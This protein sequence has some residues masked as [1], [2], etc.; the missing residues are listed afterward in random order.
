MKLKKCL[1]H[2]EPVYT[3]KSICPKCSK[4][5]EEA[6]YKFIK[7]KEKFRGEIKWDSSLFI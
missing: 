6:H 5:S 2:P 3:L 7:S 1:N 4:K